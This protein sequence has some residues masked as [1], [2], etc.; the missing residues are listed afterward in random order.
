M[1]RKVTQLQIGAKTD[2][3][4]K[5]D[6]NEDRFGLVEHYKKKATWPLAEKKG[7]LY[8]VAD[9]MGGHNAGEVASHLAVDIISEEYYRDDSPDVENSLRQA[10]EEAN[11]QVY[12]RAQEVR[13]EA[14]MGSTIVAA[15]IRGDELFVAHAGDSR[16]YRIR[17][18]S[19][20]PLT[21]DHSWV[22]EQ[23]ARNL[24]TPEQARTHPYRNY[25]T[26]SLGIK[27][28]L[29][30]DTN[31]I[32]IQPGDS[33]LLCSDGLSGQLTDE[34]IRDVVSQREPADACEDLVRLA[35]ET[36]GPDNIT[37]VV[38][39]VDRVVPTL[40]DYRVGVPV[41]APEAGPTPPQRKTTELLAAEEIRTAERH[42]PDREPRTMPM[43]AG[44]AFAILTVLALAVAAFFFRES[45]DLVQQN[46]ALETRV[47]AAESSLTALAEVSQPT[48]PGP[49]RRETPLPPA[50]P[51]PTLEDTA[52]P[53]GRPTEAP[54]D[55]PSPSPTHSPTAAPT[56]TASTT[57]T[58]TETLTPSPTVWPTPTGTYVLG[59]VSGTGG[60][61]LRL[62]RTP[63]QNA[64]VV[65]LLEEGTALLVWGRNLGGGWL[66]VSTR[67]DSPY[68]ELEGWVSA[69]YVDVDIEVE[70][71][72]VFP[73][74]TLPPPTPT[75]TLPTEEVTDEPTEEPTAEP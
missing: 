17:E 65:G 25:I 71:L 2:V 21:E 23:L 64:P 41:P 68:G 19:I 47:R 30:V 58:P 31:C 3:G 7:N 63:G 1:P 35:N 6:H 45:Q 12:Q 60:A 33:Y 9:G 29:E 72:P 39:R 61:G 70:G 27:P 5:R 40:A 32:T 34:T 52:L 22:R 38:M 48:V 75:D 8:I 20:E 66:R 73:T 59:A 50:S 11:R 56:H 10:I 14:G 43:F 53:A 51:R 62:R 24:I 69:E 44:I 67:G 18:G 46:E 74:A 15:V 49:P 55:T 54:T 13:A 4:K 57:P 36:G 42:S 28:E 37:A 16:A 26:R